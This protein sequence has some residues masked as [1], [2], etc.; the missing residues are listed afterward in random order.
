MSDHQ[1][2]AEYREARRLEA[3]ARLQ[4]LDT[5]SEQAFDDLTEL[6]ARWLDTPI[7]LVSL[8]DDQRQWFKS[9]V[10]LAAEQTP[11][12]LAF[13]AHAIQAHELF[14]VPDAARDERF[15]DN[16]LVTGEPNI[17]FYAGMPIAS[18]DG[19]LVG[20][21]CVIDR[22]PRELSEV[23]QDTLRR[24]ART[25]EFQ[26]Q[27]RISLLES[28]QRATELEHQ[29]ALNQRLLDSITA[30]VV[31][32]NDAGEL[33]L[34]NNTARLW[35]GTD[36]MK[37]PASE[38]GL[39]YDLY[40]PDGQTPLAIEAIPLLRAWRGEAVEN[41]EISIAAVG[42]PLR[43]VLC[44]GG[45]LYP[46]HGGPGAAIVVMHDITEIRRAS[47]LKSEFLATVSHELRTPLTAINGAIGL[48]RSG[49][50]G[51][52]PPTSERLLRIAQENSQR[53]GELIN[54]L[55]DME[56]LEAGQLDLQL[57]PQLLRPIVQNALEINQPYARRYQV[58]WQLESG[59][60]DP[61][62]RVDER[63]LQQVL[64]NY[65][66][67]A[68]KFSHAGGL[69]QVQLLIEGDEVEVQVVDQGIGIAEEQQPLLFNKFIQL[70]NS[71]ARQRGGTGLGLAICKE[72]VE[73][74]DGQ[75]GV[76]SREGAGSCFWFRLPLS[77]A[78]L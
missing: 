58:S 1:N 76:R 40:E 29:Q 18:P 28:E 60:A 27:L 32:C 36:V 48:L 10:G 12:E 37:I 11:R 71:N 16:P 44:S 52:L 53:L 20:T 46:E 9:R 45:Q 26:L 69:I 75:V 39:Y 47:N 4:I 66:S 35:H 50:I 78:V 55:L 3:L 61:I 49:A 51:N 5:P 70:D 21:L 31:A 2:T 8:V 30:G 57:K 15:C 23:Q 62:V 33:T 7:A 54:D 68:A 17:R 73:R 67:N 14:E 41:T 38:W 59:A 42:Q 74:M 25:A 13:C 64:S 22:V 65:L 43:Q 19:E 34:F 63:R 77:R 72:L 6:A 24:L 56:K